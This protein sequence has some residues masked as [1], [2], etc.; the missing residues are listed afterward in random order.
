MSK[1]EAMVRY[2]HMLDN[3][4]KARALTQGKTREDLDSEWV[5][6]LALV[7]LLEVIGEAANR[8]PI[9]EQRRH[10]EIPWTQII[11]LR[12]RLIHGYDSIDFD[13]LWQIVSEDLAP[14]IVSLEAIVP[15][16]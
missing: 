5:D 12:N 11:G 13:I 16:R 2:R 6:T 7:R 3:A 10:P 1:H 9:E 14:L 15:D 4:R 8:V